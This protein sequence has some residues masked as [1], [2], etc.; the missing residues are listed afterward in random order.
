MRSGPDDLRC[1]L[2]G[3]SVHILHRPDEDD[4]RAE[5]LITLA[6]AGS[7][8]GPHLHPGQVEH[9]RVVRGGVQVRLGDDTVRAGAGEAVTVPAGTAH[10][11]Q[12]LEA[13]TQL[14]GQLTPGHGFEAALEDVYE[15]LDSGQ[16]GPDGP[17]DPAVWDECFA[18]HRHIMVSM[19]N[20]PAPGASAGA[21]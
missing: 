6:D 8:P 18:R 15:L 19:R 9:F 4:E 13:G 16:L 14:L 1:P 3:E 5:F 7:G 2:S 17:V 11:F 21:D 20:R 10:S 12:A